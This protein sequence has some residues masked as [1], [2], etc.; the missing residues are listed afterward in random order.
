MNDICF[1][2]Q[3]GCE[4]TE[5]AVDL[6]NELVRA[7]LAAHDTRAQVCMCICVCNCNHSLAYGAVDLLHLPDISR[8]LA[9]QVSFV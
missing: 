5:F 9:R 1:L 2:P 3:S 7:F 6:I 4:D 8:F